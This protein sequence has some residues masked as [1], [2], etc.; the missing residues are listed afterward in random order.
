[1]FPR[2]MATRIPPRVDYPIMKGKTE[3]ENG[4]GAFEMCKGVV[5]TG[6]QITLVGRVKGIL[7]LIGNM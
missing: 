2:L 3:K 7:R 4:G 6:Y 1:M 5:E